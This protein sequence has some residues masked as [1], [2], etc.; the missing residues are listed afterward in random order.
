MSENSKEPREYDAV[1]GG[2]NTTPPDAAVLGGIAG[3]KSRL[4]SPVIEARIA[5]LSAAL[6]YGQAGLDLII[7]ALRDESMQVKFAAYALLKERDDLKIELNFPQDYLPTFEFDVITVDAER[8]QNI[9][10]KSFAC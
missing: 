3:V 7:G 5:A 10:N 9:G 8:K 2:Q 1:L 6:K 4:A